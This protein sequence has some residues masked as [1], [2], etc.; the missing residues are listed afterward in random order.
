M[1]NFK[2]V[3]SAG[4]VP[5][6]FGQSFTVPILKNNLSVYSK[7]TPVE[8]FRGISISPVISK[9]ADNY[10]K[11]GSTVNICALDLSKAF[12]NMNHYGLFIRLMQRHLP[13]NV[14][15]I[16]VLDYCLLHA[17]HM[18]RVRFIVL[19]TPC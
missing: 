13:L 3:L 8:D 1:C 9:V 16:F 5:T 6:D 12:D 11:N 18:R 4:C 19:L 2:L 10:V 14:L 17:Y 7:S 15:C